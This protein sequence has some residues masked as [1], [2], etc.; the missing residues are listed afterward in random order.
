MH[1]KSSI[2]RSC[3]III[4]VEEEEKDYSYSGFTQGV[5]NSGAYGFYV[6]IASSMLILYYTVGSDGHFG[7]MNL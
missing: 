3:V 4:V 2:T 7:E 5:T 1:S 6:V